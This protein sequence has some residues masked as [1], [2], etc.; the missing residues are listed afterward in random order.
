MLA[1]KFQYSFQNLQSKS[2]RYHI[3]LLDDTVINPTIKLFDLLMF[4]IPKWLNFDYNKLIR[5]KITGYT[6]P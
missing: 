5:G 4:L 1:Q 2:I 6:P 3:L